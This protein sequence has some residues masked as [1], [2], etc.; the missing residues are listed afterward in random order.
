MVKPNGEVIRGYSRG[1]SR[2]TGAFTISP[3]K[4]LQEVRSGIGTRTLTEFR[5]FHVDRLGRRFE[6]DREQRTWRGVACT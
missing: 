5:K 3:A 4:S 1:A 6:I 2:S